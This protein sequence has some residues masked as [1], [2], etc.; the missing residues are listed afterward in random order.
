MTK[1]HETMREIHVGGE[2]E[3]PAQDG[4]KRRT[5]VK[6]TAW[7]IPV[8][9]V[10]MATPAAAASEAFVCPTVPATSGWSDAKGIT[11]DT[12]GTGKYGWTNN[13]W[14]NGKDAT[15]NGGLEYYIEFSFKGVAG[16]SYNFSWSA[17]AGGADNAA[18]YVAYDTVIDGKTVYTASSDGAYGQGASFLDPNTSARVAASRTFTPTVDGTYTFRYKVRLSQLTAKQNSNHNLRITM[19]T[20]TC[21]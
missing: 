7:T 11:G 5:I 20:L 10:A 12:S 8:V 18:S 2:W 17:Y 3:I 4:L 6:G 21:S 19:P 14:D 9:A 16:H 1:Q 13:D 15:K